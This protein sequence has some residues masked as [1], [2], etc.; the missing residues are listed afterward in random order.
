MFLLQK[1]IRQVFS[2]F[3][4]VFGGGNKAVS[5]HAREKKQT[6]WWFQSFFSIFTPDPWFRNFRQFDGWHIFQM[7]W[8]LTTNSKKVTPDSYKSGS[9]HPWLPCLEDSCPTPFGPRPWHWAAIIRQD[10]KEWPFRRF[11]EKSQV[12]WK[13]PENS[14]RFKLLIYT[15]IIY[16]DIECN[17]IEY[18][19]V[20]YHIFWYSLI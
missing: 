1:K 15:V 14:L 12:F 19:I 13:I 9:I 10:P 17:M 20:R 11:G 18:N 6:R 5:F 3:M 8:N 2:G 7:G 4:L 16:N